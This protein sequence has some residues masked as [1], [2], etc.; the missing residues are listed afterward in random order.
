MKKN[1]NTGELIIANLMITFIF[2]AAQQILFA[3]TL[4]TQTQIIMNQNKAIALHN[5]SFL[6]E[7]RLLKSQSNLNAKL[8]KVN[9]EVAKVIVQAKKPHIVYVNDKV[10][11]NKEIIKKQEIIKFIK[12]VLPANYNKQPE[13]P[14]V[15]ALFSRC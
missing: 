1:N 11:E 7:I 2:F 3:Y 4:S 6:N 5:K 14:K 9:R 12:P 13:C 10:V 8:N 15:H